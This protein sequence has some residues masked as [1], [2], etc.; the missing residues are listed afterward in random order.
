MWQQGGGDS[1]VAAA[2]TGSRAALG[3]CGGGV[4]STAV[5][6]AAQ[7]RLC[8]NG[9]GSVAAGRGKPPRPKPAVDST[10]LLSTSLV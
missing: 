5:A 2:M 7:Q 3:Y 6:T 9:G 8:G 4:D 10:L 1:V